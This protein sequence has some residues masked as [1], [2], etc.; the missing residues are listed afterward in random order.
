MAGHG[1][2]SLCLTWVALMVPPTLIGSLSPEMPFVVAVVAVAVIV[3][4]VV[5]VVMHVYVCMFKF[6]CQ[7]GRELAASTP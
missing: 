3:V 7:S 4:V 6:D 2:S 5:V 1:L